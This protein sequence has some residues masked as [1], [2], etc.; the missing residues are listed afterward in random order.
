[1][2]DEKNVAPLDSMQQE[3]CDMWEIDNQTKN[4]FYYDE[5]N[6]CRKFWVDDSKQQFN[7]D[8]TADFVLA[9]LVKK[10]ET[11]TVDVSLETFRKPLKLQGNVE[12]IKFSKLYAKGD[13][14]QC[15]KESGK[16][17]LPFLINL[18]IL[19]FYRIIISHQYSR[20]CI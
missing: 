9:G 11:L 5:S 7:M 16:S 8:Y 4:V 15:V 20:T 12:E 1:M 13:F 14:L 10:K 6:N 19:Q 17:V 18:H 2:T 3:L